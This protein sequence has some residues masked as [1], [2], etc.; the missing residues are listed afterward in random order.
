VVIGLE[1]NSFL[2]IRVLPQAA[3]P[4]P[5]VCHVPVARMSVIGHSNPV[6]S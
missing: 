4:E 1:K 3:R 2:I 6:G 5:A